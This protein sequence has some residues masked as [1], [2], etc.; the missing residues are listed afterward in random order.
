MNGK[1]ARRLRKIAAGIELPPST[2][3]TPGG[4]LRRR[5]S[6]TE[7]DPLTGVREVVPGA[8]IPRPMVL[9][10]CWRRAYR[11]AKKIYKGLPPSALL[12]QGENKEA[13]FRVRMVDSIKKQGEQV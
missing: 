13:P 4:P 7:I 3:Y 1:T 5:A 8:P 11:E 6:R 2:S 10:E 9:E 12:P